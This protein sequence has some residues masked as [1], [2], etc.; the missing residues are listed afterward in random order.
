M[1]TIRKAVLQHL[2][3]GDRCVSNIILFY[4]FVI[5]ILNYSKQNIYAKI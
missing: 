1:D 2:K 3:L 4:A 5:E